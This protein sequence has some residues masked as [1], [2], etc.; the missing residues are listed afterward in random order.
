MR[1]FRFPLYRPPSQV[2]DFRRAR[3]M[4]G[5]GWRVRHFTNRLRSVARRCGH[6]RRG[7]PAG[8]KAFE[9]VSCTNMNVPWRAR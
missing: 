6:E 4:Y 3:V 9:P 1:D 2:N 7:A 8:G 5:K